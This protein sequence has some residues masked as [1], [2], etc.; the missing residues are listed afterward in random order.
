M[1]CSAKTNYNIKELFDKIAGLVLDKMQKSKDN[2]S[3]ESTQIKKK[4]SNHKK[5][6]P[7]CC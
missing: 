3:R 7:D 5:G 4:K 1:Y 6:K 2:P